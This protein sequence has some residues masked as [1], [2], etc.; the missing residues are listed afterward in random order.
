MKAYKGWRVCLSRKPLHM[1]LQGCMCGALR[2]L[3]PNTN[4][5]LWRCGSN[6]EVDVD[7]DEMDE[8]DEMAAGM[9]RLYPGWIMQV[10]EIASPQ[11]AVSGENDPSS[12]TMHGAEELLNSCR[13][14]VCMQAET[15]RR[16]KS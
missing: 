15:L 14:P 5:T 12:T 10:F 2:A 13:K 4:C 16:C 8:M 1:R 3:V 6:L 11:A 7:V 9:V